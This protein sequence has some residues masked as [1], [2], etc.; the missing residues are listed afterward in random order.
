VLKTQHDA[1]L[2]EQEWRTF[3]AAQDF[4]QLIAS[5]RARDV[6]V[7]VPAHYVFDGHA[8]VELHLHRDNPV[9]G[10]LAESAWAVFSVI[11]AH[12]YVPTQWN[13]ELDMDVQWSAPTSYYA[14]VQVV[15]RATVVDD[16][17]TLAALLRRQMERMQ[18]E[19]GHAAVEPGPTPYG[20]MLR[21]IRGVSM[22]ALEVRAKFKFGGNRTHDH[23][24]RIAARLAERGSHA[25]RRAREHM[26]RRMSA[27]RGSR[28]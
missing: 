27:Q 14:A 10:A 4:G 24:A 7:V 20:R 1:A 19:G 12:T 6:P 26:L 17:E 2:S 5:G 9:W 3:L 8:T 18:P 16:P 23:Q 22:Q 21:G 28:A 11:D 25:D 13:A 15:G